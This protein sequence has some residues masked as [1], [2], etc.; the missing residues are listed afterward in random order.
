MEK[1]Q[2]KVICDRLR[3]LLEKS[4]TSIKAAAKRMNVAQPVLWRQLHAVDP[5]PVSRIQE[6]I[7][8]WSPSEEEAARLTEYVNGLQC[9]VESAT[10]EVPSAPDEIPAAPTED[11]A[12]P[13]EAPSDRKPGE[14]VYYGT[15]GSVRKGIFCGRTRDGSRCLVFQIFPKPV[16]MSPDNGKHE[17]YVCS[18]EN[19]GDLFPT[20]E[21][22]MEHATAT[23]RA[24]MERQIASMKQDA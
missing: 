5:M 12:A 4:G 20:P 10:E 8:I 16:I 18:L 13:A 15:W 19:D 21:A 11:P 9:L 7:N 23:I 22:L 2:D 17:Y 14:I 3:D 24:S 1:I 6:I